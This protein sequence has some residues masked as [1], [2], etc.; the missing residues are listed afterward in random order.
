MK[1]TLRISA[2]TC[3]L[4][5][6]AAVSA[7][8]ISKANATDASLRKLVCTYTLGHLL[9]GAGADDEVSKKEV[10]YYG[11]DNNLAY[12]AYYGV[13][14]D[15]TF[16]LTKLVKYDTYERNDSIFHDAT[17]YQWG[18]YN[19]GDMAMKKS[20]PSGTVSQVYDKDG[21]LLKDVQASYTYEYV[22]DSEGKVEKMTKS[23]T[24][25]GNVSE[26]CTYAYSD[27]KVVGETATDSKDVFKYKN[28]YEYDEAG[29]KTTCVQW[30]R[31]TASDETTE[32]ISQREEWKYTDGVLTEYIKY[33]GGKAP[34]SEG[35]EATEPTPNTRK[36]YEV[37]NGNSNQTL[38]TSYTYS[39]S[40][41]SWNLS[42]NPT[43]TEYADFSDPETAAMLYGTEISA[44]ADKSTYTTTVSFTAPRVAF[45]KPTKITLLRDGH[46]VKTITIAGNAPEELDTSTGKIT[47]K[48]TDV[49]AGH[50]DYF[51]QT[52][53][54]RGEELSKP[55][56]LTW[57]PYNITNTASVDVDY[58]F[59]PVTDLRMTDSKKEVVK[60]EEDGT[61]KIERTATIS[62]TLPEINENSG[63]VKNELYRYVNS[64]NMVSYTLFDYTEDATK[65]SMEAAYPNAS[66]EID[67]LVVS[68]YKFGTVKS[69]LLHITRDQLDALATRIANTNAESAM[70][71]KVGND[72]VTL[73]GKA[74]IRIL[75]LDGKLLNSAKNA[76]SVSTG[77]VKGAYIVSVEKDGK[78]VKTVKSAK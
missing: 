27:G 40:S 72:A 66:D 74:N 25:S 51:V 35:A 71:V 58:G 67:V 6:T 69:E 77:N 73:S 75:S 32:Y 34:A 5:A 9:E 55:D 53:V 7:Q 45:S 62:Y 36:T 19:F 29:N 70:D 41:Q 8:N 50:H 28:I 13:N 15:K 38:M 48:D 60:D 18:Q 46:I 76:S 39:K 26:I 44:E 16:T 68:H 10:N 33:T 47:I 4:A 61:T 52:A 65:T 14:A 64:F 54:G 17:Y 43:V 56:E 23:L 12:T 57:T 24:T 31:K 42:G 63:F 2:L 22:Y 37:Y 30:K 20:Q 21:K 3:C 49:L 59:K 1:K 11:L 78:I